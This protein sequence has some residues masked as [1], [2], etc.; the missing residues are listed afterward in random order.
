VRLH[1]CTSSYDELWVL[2]LNCSLSV[3]VVACT[4]SLFVIYTCVGLGGYMQSA[5]I[6]ECR[7]GTHLKRLLKKGQIG[8]EIVFLCFFLN[9]LWVLYYSVIAHTLFEFSSKY[10][11]L[12]HQTSKSNI[13]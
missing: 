7:F 3:S 8:G 4:S 1:T 5:R 12:F 6:C 9:C 13:K 2:V 11:Y 10:K